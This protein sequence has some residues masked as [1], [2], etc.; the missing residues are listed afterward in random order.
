M[1][2]KEAFSIL[3]NVVALPV[4]LREVLKV[5]RGDSGAEQY[6]TELQGVSEARPSI[7]MNGEAACRHRAGGLVQQMD[8]K[9]WS[10][11]GRKE[12]MSNARVRG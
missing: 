6:C 2:E 12:P 10:A 7:N 4:F 9:S 1:N 11:F 3:E 5:I 8:H